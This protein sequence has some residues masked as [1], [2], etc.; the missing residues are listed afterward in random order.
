MS[1]TLTWPA[2]TCF[3]HLYPLGTLGVPPRNTFWEQCAERLTALYTWLDYWLELGIGAVHLGPIFTS[4]AHGY[5]TADYFKI[6]ADWGA[7]P[8]SRVYC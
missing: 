5:D 6:A 4:S 7:T 2:A 1:I 3:S 8:L